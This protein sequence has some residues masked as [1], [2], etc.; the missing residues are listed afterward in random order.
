MSIKATG[1]YST[2]TGGQSSTGNNIQ[3]HPSPLKR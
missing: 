3:E 1:Q 2:G